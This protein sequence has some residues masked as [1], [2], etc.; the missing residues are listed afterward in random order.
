M[1]VVILIFVILLLVA[2][3]AYALL[4]HPFDMIVAVIVA[5]VAVIYLVTHLD[6]LEG[7]DAA[8]ASA[9]TVLSWRLP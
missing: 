7:A 1:L 8:L 2:Y 3:G 5:I 6:T 4:P 9:A